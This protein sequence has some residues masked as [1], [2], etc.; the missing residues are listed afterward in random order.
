MYYID[1]PTMVVRAFDFNLDD[2]TLAQ[3]RTVL[4][5]PDG[6]GRPDGMTLD[7]D[8]MLWIAHWDGGRVTRWDPRSG[9]LL[10]TARLPVD[11]VTSCTFGGGDLKTLFITTASHGLSESQRR[12]QPHAGGLFALQCV[13]G[14]Q[15]ANRYAG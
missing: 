8:G 13:V 4:R 11:R 15:P 10:E 2:G 5:F 6:V 14:G 7:N 3:E 9:N 1:T 12:E